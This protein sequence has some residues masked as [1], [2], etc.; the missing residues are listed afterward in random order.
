[1]NFRETSLEAVSA[2]NTV[3]LI[4]RRRGGG[5]AER[6]RESWNIGVIQII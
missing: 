2:I 4:L 3:Y 6:E 1:M 5:G